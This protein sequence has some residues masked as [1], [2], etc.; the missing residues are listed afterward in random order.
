MSGGLAGCAT[1][2]LVALTFGNACDATMEWAG[3]DGRLTA[4]PR[5][6]VMSSARGE[7]R[8]GLEARRDGVLL[9]PA[10]VGS[11][12]VPLL[13]VLHGAGG[14]GEAVLGRVREAA[15]ASG[16]VVLAPDSRD[17]TWDAVRAGFGADVPFIDRALR[18]VFEILA[19]DPARVAI[20]GF[21]DGATYALSLGLVNGDLFQRV[22]A[23]SPGFLVGGVRVG[24]PR[25]FISHGTSDPVLPIEQTSLLILPGLRARGY[26]VTFREF[27]GGH[28]VPPAIAREGVEWVRESSSPPR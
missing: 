3:N 7:Q 14:R 10:S 17:G 18:H 23:F 4:R 24:K 25:V 5:S 2:A 16:V 12:P 26:E 1:L 28:E 6:G 22:V 19:V 27:D 9:V 13:L 11:D 20:G 15:E 21:S 8:L